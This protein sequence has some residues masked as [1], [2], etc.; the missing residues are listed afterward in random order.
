MLDA[1]SFVC[2]GPYN[3]PTPRNAEGCL[4]SWIVA[5]DAE[6]YVG[7]PHRQFRRRHVHREI[8][9]ACVGYCASV[10]ITGKIDV[11]TGN[12]G[13][14]VFGGNVRLKFLVQWLAASLA[15]RNLRYYTFGDERLAG[16]LKDM[17]E[18]IG[19]WDT[20]QLY[21]YL[22]ERASPKMEMP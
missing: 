21:V 16:V 2:E 15:G 17:C 18:R 12:W 4:D 13:C 10:S 11:A 14:G 3:D 9:K 1:D 6:R 20:H 8:H 22:S 5:I 19:H 7:R